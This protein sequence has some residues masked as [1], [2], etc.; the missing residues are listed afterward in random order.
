MKPLLL[1]TL[2]AAE[3][4]ESPFVTLCDD[5]P[6]AD[7]ERWT[8]K[9]HLSHLSAWREHAARLLMAASE[10]RAEAEPDDI[11][12]QNARIFAATSGRQAADV[13]GAAQGSYRTLAA[14]INACSEAQLNGPRQGRPGEVWRVVPGNGHPHVAQHL[15]QWYR[16]YGDGAAA[17]A[18]SRWMRELD[19]LF[20]DTRS[21]AVA[22]Y[23]QACFYAT[24]GDAV[25]A[26]PLLRTSLQIDPGLREWI[27]QDSDLDP[28]RG[29]AAVDQLL[30]E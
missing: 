9:D 18:A 17:E 11:D 6:A 23:N 10:G 4:R 13:I 3:G 21:R 27:A 19:D 22:A 24:M 25:R 26:L 8:A 12:A 2:A 14:A 7:P 15:V 1:Q 28:I 5:A 29:D 30:N 16:E 20:T